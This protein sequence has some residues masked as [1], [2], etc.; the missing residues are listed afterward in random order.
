MEGAPEHP[1]LCQIRHCVA[2]LKVPQW[3]NRW[4]LLVSSCVAELC[5]ELFF[6]GRVF[7]N[8]SLDRGWDNTPATQ[9]ALSTREPWT[10]NS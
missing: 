5:I 4:G 3:N 6:G 10:M 9:I 8:L 1:K 7:A 2:A